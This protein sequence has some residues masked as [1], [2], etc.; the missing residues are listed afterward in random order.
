MTNEDVTPDLEEIEIAV[1]I[2]VCEVVNNSKKGHVPVNAI[3]S[4]FP[5]NLRG[6]AET[7]LKKG[8][9]RKGYVMRHPTGNNTTYQLTDKGFKACKIL[10]DNK[11][12]G[13]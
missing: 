1:L 6:D 5:T 9:I 2:A 10:K 3:Q 13:L 7:I 11:L 8:L 12:R 4:K